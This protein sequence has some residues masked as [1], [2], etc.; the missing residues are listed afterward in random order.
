MSVCH[1]QPRYIV[2]YDSDFSKYYVFDLKESTHIY[3]EPDVAVITC[4]LLNKMEDVL[5]E[6]DA[7]RKEMKTNEK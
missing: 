3:V 7:L 1:V 2:K 5:R 6:I 4:V